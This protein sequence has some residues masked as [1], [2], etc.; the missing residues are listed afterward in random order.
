[1]RLAFAVVLVFGA[2]ALISAQ[3]PKGPPPKDTLPK[4]PDPR[5]GV[6]PRVKAYPQDTPRA[7]LKST[8]TAIEKADYSYLVAQLLDPKFVDDAVAERAK[9]FEAGAEV[10]LAQL[11]DFQ[12]KNPS[13][14][15]DDNRVPLDPV[16]FRAVAAA[17][18]RERGF[19]QLIRDIEQKLTDDPQVV[20][21]FRRIAR[22][23]S[24]V[25][26]DPVT[27]ATHPEIKARTLY[28]KKT[29]GRWF[30]EN[31]QAEEKKEP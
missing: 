7:A 11:R 12:R 14:V 29:A 20:K 4:D 3:P 13:S 2:A 6:N 24:F 30:L 1:M 5:Y 8:L 25:D 31:R 16:A 22:D 19:K 28:F 26:A 15:T 18:A 21:D 17:K 9:L 10:E 27:S 23:G